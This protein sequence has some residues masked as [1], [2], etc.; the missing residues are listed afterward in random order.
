[1]FYR[2]SAL[3]V[4]LAIGAG[5]LVADEKAKKSYEGVKG[6]VVNFDMSK[7]T[8]T[9]KTGSGEKG[10][11]VGD[12]L[13]VL[14]PGGQR[15]EVSLK[16]ASEAKALQQKWTQDRQTLQAVFSPGNEVEL[17]LGKDDTVTAVTV[18]PRA[19][20]PNGTQPMIRPVPKRGG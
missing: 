18:F 14:F 15:F 4:V 2:L 20:K 1:M 13:V 12:N 7:K 19:G 17:T 10:Y 5:G 8:V 6:T 3:A 9:L 16:M 11:T